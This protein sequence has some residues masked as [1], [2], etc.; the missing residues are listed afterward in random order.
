MKRKIIINGQF[1]ARRM[2]GQ[3]RFAREIVSAWD[4]S[5]Y[6]D[7]LDMVL[8]VPKNA[9]NI[10]PLEHIKVVKY[11]RVKGLLWEQTCLAFY[12]MTHR[13]VSVNLCSVMPVFRPGIICIHDLSYKV[14]PQYFTTLYARASRLWH[15]L[16]YSLARRL[17]PIIFTVS[18]YSKKQMVDTYH[19]PDEKVVVVGN[20]WEHFQR[21]RE[22][23]TIKTRRPELFE[24]PYFFSLSNLAPNKNIEWILSVA[25]THPQYNFL[26]AGY[27]NHK[28]YSLKY[29]KCHYPNV[30]FLGYLSDGEIKAL[31]KNC[32]AFVFP[33]F[34]EG[35]GIPPLEALSVGAKIIVARNSCLPE[36]YGQS[37]Y[38]IDAQDSN[39]NL[40]ELLQGTVEDSRAVLEKYRFTKFAKAMFDA[41]EK[42]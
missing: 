12:L 29:E 34:F 42:V 15:M 36:I 5:D 16:Q 17:S 39:V 41:I 24:K 26:I 28:A 38:Y 11:G 22:D 18:E 7:K 21:T 14:N 13:A 35:F 20:G 31:M 9:G 33:S 30:R 10:P 4:K 3:E 40:D 19:V 27:R 25:R 23:E 32:K 8:V 37:A 2:T 1:T 6:I